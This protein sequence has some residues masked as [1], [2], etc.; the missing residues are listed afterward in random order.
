MT[1]GQAA[2]E[3]YC[4]SSGGKSLV[5]G[6]QLPPFA[7]LKPEIRSAWEA[8]GAAAAAVVAA[9]G[10]GPALPSP[11][12]MVLYET[13]GRGGYRYAL[14]AVVVRTR[15]STDPRAVADGK[16]AEL[17]DDLTVDLLV[18][19]CGGE[20]YGEDAVPFGDSIPNATPRSWRWPPREGPKA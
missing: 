7:E 16:V 1:R 20:S 6:A 19:S 13:D 5:T 12:R 14:P 8:A 10:K 4:A 3:A 11:C 2:Y 15:S 9:T 17:P 18:F